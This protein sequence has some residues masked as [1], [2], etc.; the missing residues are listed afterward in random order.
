MKL[1]THS[2]ILGLA[3]CALLLLTAQAP[4][5]ADKSDG[6]TPTFKVGDR[7]PDATLVGA[8]GASVRLNEPKA[9]V[10]ILSIVPL[11]NTPV[12]DE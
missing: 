8:G 3:T 11:L 9:R 4:A 7:L 10:R 12:C 1:P 5:F 2:E 6:S